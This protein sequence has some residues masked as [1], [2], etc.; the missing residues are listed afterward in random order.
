MRVSLSLAVLLSF[1]LSGS[2]RIATAAEDECVEVPP[3]LVARI[4]AGMEYYDVWLQAPRAVRTY[5]FGLEAWFVSADVGGPEFGDNVDMAHWLVTSLDPETAEIYKVDKGHA[6]YLSSLPD[7]GEA[8]FD[9]GF[10]TEG[11]GAGQECSIAAAKETGGLGID[12]KTWEE[13][14]GKTK[15]VAGGFATTGGAIEFRLKEGRIAGVTWTLNERRPTEEVRAL[16]RDLIPDDALLSGASA[17]AAR[18]TVDQPD[19]YRSRWLAG[20]FDDKG[21]WDRGEPGTF[22]VTYNLDDVGLVESFALDLGE[23]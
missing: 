4:Q 15:D 5:E 14:H 23:T 22:S 2:P 7:A 20:R 3:G 17:E 1:V 13:R 8:G 9:V 12:R 10:F 6:D 16:S 19:T 11:L 21:L 18:A